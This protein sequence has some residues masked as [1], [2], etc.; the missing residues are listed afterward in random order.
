M[1]HNKLEHP[2]IKASNQFYASEFLKMKRM[3]YKCT[4]ISSHK[5]EIC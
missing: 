3:S 1:Q 2:S 4:Q 5:E